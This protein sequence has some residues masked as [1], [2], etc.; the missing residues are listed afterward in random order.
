MRTAI[1]AALGLAVFGAIA[2]LAQTQLAS[3]RQPDQEARGAV[4]QR[5]AR[6]EQL[7][8]T[9]GHEVDLDGEIAVE[10][11]HEQL[12]AA[13]DVLEPAAGQGGERRVERLQSV[14]P[15]R[16]RRRAWL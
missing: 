5:R 14:D 4:A 8:A 15:W 16:E 6:V 9:G 10:L 2:A 1:V 11:D 13:S 7:Q 3:I 12:A